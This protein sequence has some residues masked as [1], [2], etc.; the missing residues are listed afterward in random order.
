M[1]KRFC[2]GNQF[3]VER[4]SGERIEF[5]RKKKREKERESHGALERERERE[6]E[7]AGKASFK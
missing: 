3:A 6:G 5:E 7:R 1:K 4:S 2:N